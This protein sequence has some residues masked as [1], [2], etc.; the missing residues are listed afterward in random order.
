MRHAGSR[1]TQPPIA[2]VSGY[3]ELPKRHE[4]PFFASILGCEQ[5]YRHHDDKP[6]RWTVTSSRPSYTFVDLDHV[7]KITT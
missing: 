7:F 2:S 5:P 6:V 1:H 4:C 3:Y